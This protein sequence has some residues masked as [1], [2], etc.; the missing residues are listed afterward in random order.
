M[1]G[2]S[3]GPFRQKV[4]EKQAE[5]RNLLNEEP[6]KKSA[7]GYSIS[8]QLRTK[9]KKLGPLSMDLIEKHLNDKNSSPD[10]PPIKFDH[11]IL[12]QSKAQPQIIGQVD[13]EGMAQGLGK[14]ISPYSPY[15]G[16]FLNDKR[17]GYGR[18]IYNSF[19]YVGEW[20]NDRQHGKGMQVDFKGV[21]QEGKWDKN[22]FVGE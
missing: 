18:V 11:L 20:K 17:H 4:S 12:G 21:V 15:E 10:L 19:Y 1:G 3:P 6:K 9:W 14:K 5:L 13:K 7:T 22:N 8:D 2:T 16:Q